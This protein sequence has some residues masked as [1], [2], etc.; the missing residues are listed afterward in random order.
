MSPK[1]LPAMNRLAS[2]AIALAC[3]SASLGQPTVPNDAQKVPPPQPM[4]DLSNPRKPYSLMVGDPAPAFTM[5]EWILGEPV[6]AFEPEKVYL[7]LLWAVWDEQATSIMPRLTQLQ[8]E[9][10][11]KGLVVIG[12]TSPGKVNTREAVEQFVFRGKHPVGFHIAWDRNRVVMDAWLNSSGRT[13]VPCIFIVDQEQRVAFI[14][15][16]A[17]YEKP[18]NAIIEQTYDIEYEK[19]QYSECIS[20]AWAFS[21]YEQKIQAK[22]WPQAAS[23]GRVIVGGRGNNCFAVLN[24]IAWI[25]VDPE[26]PVEQPDLELALMAATRADELAEG[27]DADTI[28]TLARVYFLKGDVQKAADLQERAVEIARSDKLREPLLKR[29]DE[30]KAALKSR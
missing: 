10:A 17:E 14:G 7:I 26:R 13:S 28:D 2:L 19:R 27:K 30:Y 25:I 1:S 20:A 21:H 5:S 12:V 3:V 16:P 6:N 11:D 4:P 24:N 18:L 15:G 29:L 23:L 22:D 9:N 8:S